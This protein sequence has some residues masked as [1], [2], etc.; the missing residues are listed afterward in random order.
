LKASEINNVPKAIASFQGPP[1]HRSAA[2]DVSAASPVH[3]QYGCRQTGNNSVF[4]PGCDIDSVPNAAFWFLESANPTI[5]KYKN[6]K[7][8]AA[9]QSR[10]YFRFRSGRIEIERRSSDK[11][12]KL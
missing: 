2:N 12:D 3:F 7:L 4:D 8:I 5:T 10:I 11:S 1:T 6:C 9:Y